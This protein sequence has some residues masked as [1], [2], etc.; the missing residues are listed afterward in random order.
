MDISYDDMQSYI[1]H[2]TAKDCDPEVIKTTEGIFNLCLW[3]AGTFTQLSLEMEK[4]NIAVARLKEIIFGGACTKT[5][6]DGE[7]LPDANNNASSDNAES[8]KTRDKESKPRKGHG[9]LGRDSYTGA[10]VISCRCDANVG[11]CC[12]QCLHG[13]LRTFDPKTTLHI[14]GHSPLMATR[15]EQE[16]LAC[17]FC[18]YVMTASTPVDT[19]QKYSE[20]AKSVLAILH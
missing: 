1:S 5:D 14:D 12:P 6:I 7:R 20:K 17:D 8:K 13:K 3:L 9:R 16:R 19:R 15:Y 10:N 4:K 2:F 18:D 11:D